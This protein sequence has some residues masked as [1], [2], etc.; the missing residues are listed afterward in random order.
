MT[1]SVIPVILAGVCAFLTLFAPQPLLPMLGDI[2]H[3]GKVMISLTVT[4]TTLGVALAAPVM[5][6]VADRVGRRR[7][8]V[9]S[10]ATLGIATLLTATSTS[11]GALLVWRFVQGVATPGVFSVTTAYV[12]DQWPAEKAAAAISAYVSGTVVGGFLGR[13]ISGFAAEHLGW[14]SAFIVLGCINLGIAGYLAFSLRADHPSTPTQMSHAMAGHLRNPQL[15]A[16]YT[17]GS[18]VLFS[19]TAMFTYVAF[20]LAAPPFS[21][22]AGL[23]GSIF[24]VYLIGAVRHAASRADASGTEGTG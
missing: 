9:A 24:V 4:A 18:C 15:V 3:A 16:A 17:V 22:S 11:L 6:Q 1:P 20:H 21:L 23:I 19:Q 12:H 5:G 13:V 10:A 2:F 8:I 7:V 14:Q